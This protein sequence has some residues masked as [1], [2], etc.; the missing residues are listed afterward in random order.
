M[1]DRP[2]KITFLDLPGS[3]PSDQEKEYQEKTTRE[4]ISIFARKKNTNSKK[5]IG[6]KVSQYSISLAFIDPLYMIL[7]MVIHFTQ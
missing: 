7:Y 6:K 1:T 3:I 2:A 5:S 4:K